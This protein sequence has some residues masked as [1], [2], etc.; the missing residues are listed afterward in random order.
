MKSCW[1]DF[2]PVMK[3]D[4]ILTNWTDMLFICQT[5]FFKALNYSIPKVERDWYL[6]KEL[7]SGVGAYISRKLYNDKFTIYQTA[8]SLL[9]PMDEAHNSVMNPERKNNLLNKPIL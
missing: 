6:N 1:T 7:G 4:V 5:E 3:G 9:I 2:Q 8:K